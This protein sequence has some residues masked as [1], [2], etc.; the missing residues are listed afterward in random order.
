MCTGSPLHSP[1]CLMTCSKVLLIKYNNLTYWHNQTKRVMGHQK[2]TLFGFDSWR[3]KLA[4][5]QGGSSY[6]RSQ[7]KYTAL[8][9][10]CTPPGIKHGNQKKV[11]CFEWS[12]P[13]HS[14]H[15]IWQ[16]ISHIYLA[17]HLAC[18]LTFYLA[19][20]PTFYLA[21]LLTFYLAFYLTFYLAYLLTFC[22]S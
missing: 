4:K 5:V 17:F 3:L 21:Y 16:P 13:W 2:W 22:A 14:I 7:K 10:Q 15:P 1:W 20:L 19:Y 12:P 9:Q 6:L 8:F 11:L 18:L